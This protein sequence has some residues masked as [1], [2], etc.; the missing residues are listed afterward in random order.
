MWIQT[1]PLP[2]LPAHLPTQRPRKKVENSQELADG[3]QNRTLR[4]ALQ[5][6]DALQTGKLHPSPLATPAF[7]PC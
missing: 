5:I 7:S 4:K 3:A 6:E 2:G 1:D